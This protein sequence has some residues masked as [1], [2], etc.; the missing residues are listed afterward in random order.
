MVAIAESPAA[1]HDAYLPF[2]EA[3]LDSLELHAGGPR[4]ADREY[5][6]GPGRG[7]GRAPR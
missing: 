1:L 2:F 7:G 5:G 6:P 3:I 4:A